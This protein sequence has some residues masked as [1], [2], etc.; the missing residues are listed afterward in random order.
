MP[1]SSWADYQ[2]ELISAGGGIFPRSAK[3]IDLTP[4]IK[5]LTGLEQDEATLAR[6]DAALEAIS[7][8]ARR[9]E[10]GKELLDLGLTA[11]FRLE[12]F[13]RVEELAEELL[14]MADA[15]DEIGRAHV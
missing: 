4:E 15:E 10:E 3:S 12:L 5:A 9:S 14:P 8:D 13:P 6:V 7:A 2:P 11:A 1:R